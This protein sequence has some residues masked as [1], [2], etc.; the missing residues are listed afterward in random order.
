[1][2]SSYFQFGHLHVPIFGV[3]AALGLV[4]ALYLS[5]RTARLGHLSPESVWNTC[6][7]AIISAF[8]ISRLLLVAFNL[9]SFLQYPFL[10]LSLPSLTTTGILLTAIFMLAYLRWRKLALLAVLDAVAPCAALLWSFL[11]LGRVVDGT[12][13]G[14][15]VHL[16]QSHETAVHPVE[17]YTFI[18]ASAI[19]L[20]LLSALRSS[21]RTGQTTAVALISAGV[22]IF[23]IDF[24]R[25]PSEL[26]ASSW[27]DPSQIMGVAML[28][29]GALILTR[30]A[31]EPPAED[32][33]KAP[34]A[35]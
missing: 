12:R 1:M 21:I 31:N 9:H 22:T 23:F 17:L 34:H 26:L 29:A 10:V 30:N 19:C 35:V 15:P 27:L 5:Q 13:N 24:F 14:M 16:W 11:S 3:F 6:F 32:R 25:L 2:H 20:Y 8:V 28:L 33:N 4:A 7:T 18:A